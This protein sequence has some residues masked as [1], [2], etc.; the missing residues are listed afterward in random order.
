MRLFNRLV[1]ECELEKVKEHDRRLVRL[2]PDNERVFLEQEVSNA[3]HDLVVH[4]GGIG[5]LGCEREVRLSL[6]VDDEGELDI[7]GGRRWDKWGQN[8][9]DGDASA[10]EVECDR[11]DDGVFRWIVRR[12]VP[13]LI[14]CQGRVG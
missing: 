9:V 2:H 13:C 3:H 6:A 11:G 1:R 7:A 8:V 5:A 10:P 12:V 14:V 4:E